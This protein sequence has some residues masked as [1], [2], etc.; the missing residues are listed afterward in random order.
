MSANSS[1]TGLRLR[2]LTTRGGIPLVMALALLFAVAAPSGAAS[3][4]FTAS[5]RSARP[6]IVLVHGAWADA[7]SWT[8]VARD[9]RHDGYRTV[10]P[11]LGLLSLAADVATVQSVLDSI[12]GPKILVA[13][14]YGGEVISAAAFGRT[15]VRGLVFSAAFVPDE[16]DS[17]ASLGTGFV[18]SEAF[19]HLAFTGTPFDSP[20]YIAPNFFRQF[21]AQDLSPAKA[22][23]LDAAQQ[24]LNFSIVTT[25]SG[26]VAWHTLPSWYAVSGQDRMIDP[27][28]ER[29]MA[30]RAGSHVVEYPNASHAGGIT[31]HATQFT[32]L[33]ERAAHAT[34]G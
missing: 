15:D 28:E 9:L 12:S 29:W 27:A 34:A 3:K 13:H 32:A 20:A 7:T 17:I 2:R 18:T 21:F 30:A 16:G 6:T 31:V 24:P 26:P 10:A 8:Q 33:V 25:P 23:L 19:A 22:A 11:D 5:T 14:S 4:T 1:P